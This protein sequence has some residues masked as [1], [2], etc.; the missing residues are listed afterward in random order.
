[1][2]YSVISYGPVCSNF[3]N[4]SQIPS[5]QIYPEPQTTRINT[6]KRYGLSRVLANNGKKPLPPR[7]SPP[8]AIVKL[9]LQRE[10]LTKWNAPEQQKIGQPLTRAINCLGLDKLQ[11]N[12]PVC[13]REIRVVNSWRRAMSSSRLAEYDDDNT[14]TYTRCPEY[15]TK[16]DHAERRQGP[17]NEGSNWIPR[18]DRK[19]NQIWLRH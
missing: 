7:S 5:R 19:R 18:V 2:V 6:T 10:L 3:D 1:M 13:C 17:P 16:N 8:K 4:V 11:K 15:V 9:C 12:N 14:I